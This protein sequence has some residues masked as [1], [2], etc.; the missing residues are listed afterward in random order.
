MQNTKLKTVAI[1]G[2]PNVGKS[3]LFNRLVGK[4]IAIETA[5]PGTTRDRLFGEVSWGKSK[6]NLMDVAGIEFGSKK[7]I[8]QSIQEGVNFAIDYAD[9][10]VFLTDWHDKNN[11]V[12]KTIARFL[13]K[14]DKPILIAVNKADNIERQEKIDEFKRLGNFPIV[15]VSAISG[16]SSGDL[17]DLIIKSLKKVKSKTSVEKVKKPTIKLAIIGRPNVGKSTL[18]NTI[19]GEK[20]AI[21][22]DE[23]GTTRDTVTIDFSHSGENIQITDT[24]GIRRPG[25]IT[26]DTIESFSVLRT[27]RALQN[28]DIA[29]LVIDANE[30]LVALDVNILGKAKEWGKGI[31]LALNKI[32]TIKEERQEFMARF[33]TE[34]QTKLNFVPW[35]PIVFISA[36]ENENVKPLFNQVISTKK[37]RSFHIP[38]GDLNQILE[39]A[40]SDNDQ[41]KGI[42]GLSQF[43]ANPPIFKAKF[44]GR[45]RLHPTQVRYLEN[46]IRD[47]Y[48]LNG[49]PIFIDLVKEAK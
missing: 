24:A 21:V 4:R 28:S 44:K 34:L 42:I 47:N 37:N 45:D 38:Q 18:L 40:K 30:G 31:I 17:L 10:I 35:L 23:P 29:I 6:F 9:L 15:P 14:T 8:D 3:T 33:L 5:I 32:D 46:R 36:K 20:R 13:R 19:I 41:L 16:K 39:K 27:M 43:K 26:K 2:R 11:E 22:S 25:K 7:E 12:D 1:I 48:P 49:T